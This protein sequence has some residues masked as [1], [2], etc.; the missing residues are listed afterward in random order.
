MELTFD[1]LDKPEEEKKVVIK[2][3]GKRIISY[4]QWSTYQ[5]CPN[6]WAQKYIFKNFLYSDSIA[7]IFGTAMHEVIQEYITTLY[8]KS[9]IAADE[10]DL[11]GRLKELMASEFLKSKKSND[12]EPPATQYEMVRHLED[13]TKILNFLKKKRQKYFPKRNYRLVGIETPIFRPASP[14]NEMVYMKGYLD[15]VLEDME[16]GRLIII[17]LKT[18]KRGWNKYA[19]AD[20]VK[21]AQMVIYKQ[22]YA[23]QYNYDVERIDIKYLILRRE[24][25]EDSMYPAPRIQNFV[26]ASGKPT[27]NK[28]MSEVS[29]FVAKGFNQDGTHN[30]KA[31]YPAITGKNKKHCKFCI[32]K[33]REDLCP[34][35]KRIKE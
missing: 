7:T 20:K 11:V 31:T 8:E 14:I 2:N 22:Y 15:V 24:I 32:F 18:S 27:R 26:P 28:V 29:A 12:G 10:M 17:D 21:T 30:D 3:D 23:D 6:S 35:D 25:D 9:G 13:G 19:K 16:T 4:S 33:D 5:K 1:A 34:K